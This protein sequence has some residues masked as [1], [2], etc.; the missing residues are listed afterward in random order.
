MNLRISQSADLGALIRARRRA[1][2]WSQAHLAALAGVGRPWLVE[3][4]QGKS[5]APMDLVI[6]ALTALGYALHLCNETPI[7]VRIGPE[8]A[9]SQHGA[10]LDGEGDLTNRRIERVATGHLPVTVNSDDPPGERLDSTV[11]RLPGYRIA[12]FETIGITDG[13]LYGLENRPLLERMVTHVIAVEGP[14]FVDL[15]ARRIAR[16]HRLSRATRKLI[17]TIEEITDGR[18]AR[19][20]EGNRTIIWP[21][22]AENSNLPPFRPAL[23]DIRDHADI[24]LVELAS[25]ATPLLT[26]GHKPEAAAIIMGRRLGLELIRPTTRSRL[27]MAAELANQQQ[28]GAVDG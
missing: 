24:P 2:R 28:Q 1:L 15:I 9:S 11:E 6:R 8:L 12:T 18:F 14:V 20:R 19:T 4:E 22:R 3:L 13:Q 21:E 25:L 23:L 27:T 16:A 7:G 10:P 26:D 17:E 5:G